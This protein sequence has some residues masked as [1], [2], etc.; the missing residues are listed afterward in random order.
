VQTVSFHLRVFSSISGEHFLFS[1]ILGDQKYWDK[2]SYMCINVV[3]S[4]IFGPVFLAHDDY[5]KLV[6]LLF[7]LGCVSDYF[8]PNRNKW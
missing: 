6:T 1:P 7:C 2:F 3:K 4:F 8:V 5:I